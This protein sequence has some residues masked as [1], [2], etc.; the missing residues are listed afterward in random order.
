ML[1]I[2]NVRPAR[3]S[4]GLPDRRTDRTEAIVTDLEQP[5]Y[6]RRERTGSRDQCTLIADGA[7]RHPSEVELAVRAVL[8]LFTGQLPHT[9]ASPCHSSGTASSSLARRRRPSPG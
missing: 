8:E 5:G 9:A 2:R 3:R 7:L 6:A 1:G 4:R